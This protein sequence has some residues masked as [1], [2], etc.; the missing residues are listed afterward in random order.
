VASNREY[1]TSS[2][3]VLMRNDLDHLTAFPPMSMT[4]QFYYYN[5]CLYSIIEAKDFA[6]VYMG[7]PEE[8]KKSTGYL[9]GMEQ[10][11]SGID[12]LDNPLI[13]K[14]HLK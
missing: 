7:A 14:V 3:Q 10:A 5:G 9:T 1:K 13:M 6:E 4:G 12:E 8:A 11:F 2:Q